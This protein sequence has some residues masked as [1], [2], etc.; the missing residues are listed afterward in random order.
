MPNKCG[1]PGVADAT[2]EVI[3]IP[4]LGVKY[5]SWCE[6]QLNANTEVRSVWQLS[7]TTIAVSLYVLLLFVF[8][9]K[10]PSDP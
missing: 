8:C 1:V 5:R 7:Q 10:A 2:E 3:P 6:R 4:A 9:L